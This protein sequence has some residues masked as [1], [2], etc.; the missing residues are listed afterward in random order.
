[1]NL[2]HLVLV[3]ILLT[4]MSIPRISLPE[5]YEVRERCPALRYHL[6]S[7]VLDNTSTVTAAP[8]VRQPM[9]I[10]I[11]DPERIRAEEAQRLGMLPPACESMYFPHV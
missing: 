2:I 4:V 10:S 8:P 1:M 6:Q 11:A 5:P 3:L 9:C 7:V